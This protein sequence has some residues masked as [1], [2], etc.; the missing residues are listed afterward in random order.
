MGNVCEEGK[1]WERHGARKELS[2]K[3]GL[4]IS[5]FSCSRFEANKKVIFKES[6]NI[7]IYYSFFKEIFPVYIL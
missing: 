5:G 7:K 2:I 3:G 1:Q 4:K 6:S